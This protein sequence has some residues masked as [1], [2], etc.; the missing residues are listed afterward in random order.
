MYAV[1]A[2][3]QGRGAVPYWPYKRSIR[4]LLCLD[5]DGFACPYATV[6]NL[7]LVF[8]S[9]N[10]HCLHLLCYSV[11]RVLYMFSFGGKGKF[12]SSTIII[13]FL[14]FCFLPRRC[15]ICSFVFSSSCSPFAL[16]YVSFRGS[17]DFLD[18]RYILV[19]FNIGKG[20]LVF[21]GLF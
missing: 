3:L 5:I 4:G 14:V 21:F 12:V 6:S 18:H 13:R 15:L 8:R 10:F 2:R 17:Y 20:E 11:V 19:L 1:A 9:G 16:L 7:H